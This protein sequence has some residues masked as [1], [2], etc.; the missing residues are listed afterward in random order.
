[1]SFLGDCQVEVRDGF[2][3]SAVDSAGAAWVAG[4]LFATVDRGVAQAL[5]QLSRLDGDRTDELV[6]ALRADVAASARGAT[7]RVRGLPQ[8]MLTHGLVLGA[9]AVPLSVT[10]GSAQTAAIERPRIEVV[11]HD[12]VAS[13]STFEPSRGGGAVRVEAAPEPTTVSAPPATPARPY[14]QTPPRAGSGGKF[15]WGW[16]TWYLSTKRF[17]PWTGDAI[18]WP[19]NARA[20]GFA[21]GSTPRVGAIFVSRESV[22]GHL[23]YVESVDANGGFTITEM[24]FRGFGVVSSRHFTKLP[25]SFVTFIY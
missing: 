1:M 17:V 12:S 4:D 2:V 6:A 21:E 10:V 15:A 20:M 25:G 11:A 8:R 19:A 7:A 24:N 23:G 3:V 5:S 18:R 14:A 16:C 13:A 22:W 9:A